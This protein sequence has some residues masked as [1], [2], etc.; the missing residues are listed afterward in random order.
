M[1]IFLARLLVA[2]SGLANGTQIAAF[3]ANNFRFDDEIVR[4]ANHQQMLDIVAPHND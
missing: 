3:G 1:L 2:G 4:P